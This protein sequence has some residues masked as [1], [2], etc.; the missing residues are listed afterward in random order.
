MNAKTYLNYFLTLK[1]ELG[2]LDKLNMEKLKENDKKLLNDILEKNNAYV[3]TC[4]ESYN[5]NKD[6]DIPNSPLSADDLN[7]YFIKNI[8]NLAFSIDELIQIQQTLS[9]IAEV[10]RLEQDFDLY[11]HCQNIC[12]TLAIFAELLDQKIKQQQQILKFKKAQETIIAEIKN[13]YKTHLEKCKDYAGIL[14]NHEFKDDNTGTPIKPNAYYRSIMNK[15]AD[16]IDKT[17]RLHCYLTGQS[18]IF[19][20]L[21]TCLTEETNNRNLNSELQKIIDENFNPPLNKENDSSLL[22]L[23]NQTSKLLDNQ[24]INFEEKNKQFKKIFNNQVTRHQNM[25]NDDTLIHHKNK[26]KEL[27]SQLSQKVSGFF[28]T[29]FGEKSQFHYRITFFDTNTRKKLERVNKE[30][31]KNTESCFNYLQNCYQQK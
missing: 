25:I 26:L 29:V 21:P 3:S 24:E 17:D 11:P 4:A 7:G 12:S 18:N 16:E 31:L 20:Q 30:R 22:G 6:A 8:S 28:Q 23:H 9:K 13:L 10:A 14:N 19:G 2:S 1:Q 27:F 5:N 15:L